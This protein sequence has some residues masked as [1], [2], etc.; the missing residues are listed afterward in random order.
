MNLICGPLI[1][2]EGQIKCIIFDLHESCRDWQ[3]LHDIP[4]LR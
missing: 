1:L 2:R 3:S 4:E